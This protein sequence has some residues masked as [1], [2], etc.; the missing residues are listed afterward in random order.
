MKILGEKTLKPLFL[1]NDNFKDNL[2]FGDYNYNIFLKILLVKEILDILVLLNLLLIEEEV[3]LVILPLIQT[4]KY[5]VKV[6]MKIFG[7]FLCINNLY[8]DTENTICS[9]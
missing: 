4:N 9:K 5:H 7:D 8:Y 6:Y 2:K 3:C 1:T